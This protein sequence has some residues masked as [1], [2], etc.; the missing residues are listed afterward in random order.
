M[1]TYVRFLAVV[2]IL[3]SQFDRGQRAMKSYAVHISYFA[4]LLVL[5]V[6]S[7]A[8]NNHTL[9]VFFG[10]VAAF[11]TD[12]LLLLGSFAIGALS[13]NL[14]VVLPVAVVFSIVASIT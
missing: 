8:M 3:H 10:S 1:L 6:F 7:F 4:I 9:A 5:L 2:Y 14:K 12:P 11:A 13:K